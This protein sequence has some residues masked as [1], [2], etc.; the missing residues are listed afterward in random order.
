MAGIFDRLN[1]E[2]ESFGRKAEKAIDSGRLQLEKFRL[3]RERD[4]AAKRLG[5]LCHRRERNLHVEVQEFDAWLVRMDVLDEAIAK[6]DR[7][8]AAAKA[9]VVSVSSD[10]PPAGARAAESDVVS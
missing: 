5:Y 2:L 4:E 3:Q 9:E 8:M 7:E 10:P 1:T 6:V